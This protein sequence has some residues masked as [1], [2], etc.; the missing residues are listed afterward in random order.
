MSVLVTD[1]GDSTARMTITI[2]DDDHRFD[3][4]VEGDTAYIEYQETL[5]WRGRV[6]VSEPDAYIF[7]ELM[8]SDE[9]SAFLDANGAHRVRR[10][11]PVS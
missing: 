6:Q 10:S 9:M 2:A 4:W 8:Q 3:V 5:T 11:E 7:K 1:H